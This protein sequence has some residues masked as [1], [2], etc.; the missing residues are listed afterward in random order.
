M[1]NPEAEEW[2]V[3]TTRKSQDHAEKRGQLI[4][5]LEDALALADEIE[6]GQT[7]RHHRAPVRRSRLVPKTSRLP[8]RPTVGASEC[9]SLLLRTIYRDLPLSLSRLA[10]MPRDRL[11]DWACRTRTQKMS[12]QNIPLKRSLRFP[13]GSGR[14][15]AGRPLAFELQR[16]GYAARGWVL[17]GS[18][19]SVLHR[20]EPC[21]SPLGCAHTF[22]V[23]CSILFGTRTL[24]MARSSCGVMGI[25]DKPIAPRSRWQ[26]PT[27][28]ERAESR[29]AS[30]LGRGCVRRR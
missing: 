2:T 27:V 7:E 10:A 21:K 3:P 1:R 25:R 8:K 11:R 16:R 23:N 9:L 13:G 5:H 30:A 17:P 28:A 15:P 14:I 6:D 24:P 29:V 18:S 22:T 12:W 19:A 20:D 4:R 26:N